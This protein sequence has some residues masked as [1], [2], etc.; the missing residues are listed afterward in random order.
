MT[1]PITPAEPGS[2]SVPLPGDSLAVSYATSPRDGH[3]QLVIFIPAAAGSRGHTIVLPANER[4]FAQFLSIL[5]A[6]SASDRS[7]QVLNTPAAPTQYI[8]DQWGTALLEKARREAKSLREV[9]DTTK[10]ERDYKKR[11]KR[12]L[13]PDLD[14]DDLLS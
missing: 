8:L 14:I 1:K 13:L 11:E 9:M 5:R 4:G 12:G 7:A 2:A 6:R 3:E 10:A